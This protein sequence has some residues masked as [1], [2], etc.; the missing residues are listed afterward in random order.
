MQIYVRI[1]ILQM[2]SLCCVALGPIYGYL[3]DNKLTTVFSVRLSIVHHIPEVEFMIS[4][5]WETNNTLLGMPAF[6]NVEMMYNMVNN[7]IDVSSEL[8]GFALDELS[9]EIENQSYTTQQAL[10][11][12]AIIFR[13]TNYMDE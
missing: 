7:T 3:H 8:S 6:M 10:N 9:D 4:V 2:F 1:I 13:Q 5:I 12:L 11:E